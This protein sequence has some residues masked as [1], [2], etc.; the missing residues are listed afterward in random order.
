MAER[1]PAVFVSH[2]APTLPLEASSA[3]EF[4]S[5]LGQTLGEPEAILVISAH[6]ENGEAAVSAAAGAGSPAVAGRR[7]HRS[8]AFGVL[9]MDA[10]RFD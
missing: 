1:F 3:R 7:I 8:H 2:G 5:G 10:N 9:A 6:W 4:L